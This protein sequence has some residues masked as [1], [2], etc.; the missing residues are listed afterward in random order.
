MTDKVQSLTVILAHDMRADD[1]EIVM[2]AISMIKHV[3]KHVGSVI[4][5]QPLDLSDYMA[6]SRAREELSSKLLEVLRP[7]KT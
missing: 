5:G 2:Q 1:A 3:G 6:R 4:P 7:E